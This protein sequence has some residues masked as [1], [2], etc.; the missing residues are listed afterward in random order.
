M[1]VAVLCALVAAARAAEA[2]GE[3][4]RALLAPAAFELES[5]LQLNDAARTDREA[6]YK[7]RARLSVAPRWTAPDRSQ[8]LL[9]FQVSISAAPLPL[10]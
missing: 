8:Y 3:A 6:G 7:L 2:E 5:T 4:R 10:S 9:H 1:C